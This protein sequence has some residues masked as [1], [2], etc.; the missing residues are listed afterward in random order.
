[1]PLCLQCCRDDHHHIIMVFIG[2]RARLHENSRFSAQSQQ[3]ISNAIVV[4]YYNATLS[5]TPTCPTARPPT[6]KPRNSLGSLAR[7]HNR[8]DGGVLDGQGFEHPKAPPGGVNQ[9]G[10]LLR[11]RDPQVTPP[12]FIAV[13]PMKKL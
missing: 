11:C 8:Q 1:M 5:A 10:H 12:M 6:P 7:R 3:S 2:A 13:G 4:F 9:G